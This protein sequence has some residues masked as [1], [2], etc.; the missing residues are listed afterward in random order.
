M[1]N[2]KLVI[3]MECAI[4][5]ALSTVLSQFAVYK[6]PYGGSITFASMVPLII[7][8]YRDGFKWGL[9]T[10]FTHSLLQMLLNFSAPPTKTLLSFVLVI[11]L[12]Y[13][14]AFTVLG[15]ASLFGKPFK[16][17]TARVAVGA[18]SVMAIRYLCHF[19][20][21]ILIWGSSAPEGTP[22]WIYSLSYNGSYMIPE[23][24]ITTIVSAILLKV[25]QLS[26]KS[27]KN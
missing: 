26:G 12:D 2:K 5:I 25:P 19:L 7:I 8:S 9:L 13:V 10:A 16:N 21:G 4:M 3:L 1:S 17:K 24:I 14:V 23:I 27:F 15:S 22:V 20:S 18:F 11:L 6:L